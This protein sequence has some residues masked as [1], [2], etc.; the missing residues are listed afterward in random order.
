MKALSE[1]KCYRLIYGDMIQYIEHYQT[2]WIN[3]FY[4]YYPGNI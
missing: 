1:R 3:N 4:L 2:Q